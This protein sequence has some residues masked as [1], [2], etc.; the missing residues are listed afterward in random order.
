[1]TPRARLSILDFCRIYEGQTPG[2]SMANSV[3]LAQQAE[4]QG[5]HRVW[6][7]EHHN[8]PNITSSSPAVLIAHIAAH[9]TSIR[10]GAG[11]IMLPNHAPYV[12]AEQFGT[13]AELHP[14]RIDLGLGRAPGTDQN[15]LGRALRRDGQAAERFPEDIRELQGYFSGRSLIP[16]VQ[17]IPGRGTNVPLY[18]LGSSLFGA[19]L[20][21]KYGLPYA[22]ASHFAPTHLEAATAYYREHFEPSEYLDAPYIIAG[23]NVLASHSAESAAAEWERVRF[24]WVKGFVGRDRYLTDSQVT[25]IMASYQG[26]QILDMLQ[27]SAVGTGAQVAEY[28]DGIEK[29]SGAD[30]LMISLQATHH[31]G[32]LDSLQLLTEAW[33]V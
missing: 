2:E 24:N 26:Q 15:T 32:V 18:V 17:A 3:E 30:E 31:A 1:M 27:Y 6:Y 23:V 8:M 19:S 14:G 11:G 21:A 10:L 28:L 4:A 7:T 5:V 29:L 16:G 13:L 20:A 22:F 12:I 33:A 25:Q 9:T